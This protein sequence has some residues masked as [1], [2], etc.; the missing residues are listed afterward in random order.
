L[1]LPAGSD[2]GERLKTIK[3]QVRRVKHGGI[4]YGML[5][6]LSSDEEVRRQLAA[7]PQAEISF[8]YL[9]R[10]EQAMNEVT[11][12]GLFHAAPERP[13]PLR[14]GAAERLYKLQLVCTVI[15]V[16]CRSIGNTAQRFITQKP[17]PDWLLNI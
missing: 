9:G 7:Q 11:E 2:Y 12:A 1:E 16:S 13:G 3:E 8:N 15:G 10:Y 5:R 17:L 14:A 6:Y 4:G